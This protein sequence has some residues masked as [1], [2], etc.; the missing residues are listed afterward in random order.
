MASERPPKL[1]DIAYRVFGLL[2]LVEVI[3][4]D[5][6]AG[7]RQTLHRGAANTARAAGNDGNAV[8]QQVT[9]RNCWSSVQ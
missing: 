9:W 4:H 5:V 8:A 6:C 3:H 1:R 2:R 7:L